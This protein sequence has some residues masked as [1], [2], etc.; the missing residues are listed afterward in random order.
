M[1]RA[2]MLV[3]T[4]LTDVQ[5]PD[6]YM[7]VQQISSNPNAASNS[8]PQPTFG[9]NWSR[10]QRKREKRERLAAS[11]G[12]NPVRNSIPVQPPI[13]AGVG[14][15]PVVAQPTGSVATEVGLSSS[16]HPGTE[17]GRVVSESTVNHSGYYTSDYARLRANMLAI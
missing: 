9:K 6:G 8:N 2:N 10:N 12:M 13:A 4:N 5:I 7:L 15:K 1:S 14:A 17:S 3:P 11:G 16:T